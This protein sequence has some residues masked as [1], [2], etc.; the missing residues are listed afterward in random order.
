MP[1]DIS[2][3]AARAGTSLPLTNLVQGVVQPEFVLKILYPLANVATYGGSTIAFDDSVFEDSDDTRADGTA[4]GEVQSGYTGGTFKLGFKGLRYL[5]P[6][7]RRKEMENL[8]VDWATLATQ[9]LAN[10]LGLRHEIECAARCTNFASYASTNRIALSAG[11]RFG[12]AGVDPDPIIRAGK[13]AV[14]NQIGLE[15][16]VAVISRAVLDALSTKYA[17]NFTSS[18]AIAG[19]GLRQQLNTEDLAAI[20]GF[21]KI[22]VCDAIVK[23]GQNRTKVFGSHMVMARVPE[24]AITGSDLPYVVNS[25]ISIV[26]PALGY[27]YVMDGHPMAYNPWY[28]QNKKTTVYDMDFDRS[29]VNVGVNPSGEITYGYFISNAA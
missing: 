25:E 27:T 26:V 9:A 17:K 4:Y 19:P 22:K 2:V 13:T 12:D 7:K 1:A 28:D 23:S 5:V 15:P 18:S 20:F 11:S 14:A 16:N 6:D 21:R 24:A 3:N 29:V 10:K 8:N